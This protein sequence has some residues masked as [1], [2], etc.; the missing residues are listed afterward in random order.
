M[1]IK[2]DNDKMSSDNILSSNLTKSGVNSDE[3]EKVEII[4]EVKKNKKQVVIGTK[5][6]EDY[7]ILLEKHFK[8]YRG[9]NLSN[10]IREL[11]FSYMRDKHLI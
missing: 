4:T 8:D 7:K 1:G 2:K 9:I 6:D 10:G 5:I 11:I 3:T